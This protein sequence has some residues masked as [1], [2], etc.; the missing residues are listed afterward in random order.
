MSVE[1]VEEA[2][3]KEAEAVAAR[4][5]E[6]ARRSQEEILARWRADCEEAF[7]QA[8]ADAKAAAARETSRQVS[9]ARHRGRMQVLAAKNEILRG[10]FEH[11]AEALKSL[12]EEEYMKM[13]ES[14]LAALSAEAGGVL[15]VSERDAARFSGE[16][17]ARLN[18]SRQAGGKFTAVTTDSGISGGFVLDGEDYTID[19]TID[20]RISDLRESMAGELAEELFGGE[21]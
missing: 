7:K 1:K 2:V 9:T 20:R 6:E 14:W 13:M 4:I 15:R 17:M 3:L 11:A 8:V 18:Q 10:V 19:Q 5:V 21:S 16:F 12:P